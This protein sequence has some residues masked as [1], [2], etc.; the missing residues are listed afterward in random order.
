MKQ[1]KIALLIITVTSILSACSSVR[2]TPVEIIT[3]TEPRPNIVLPK[4]DEFRARNVEWIVVTPENVEQVFNDLKDKNMSV[5]LFSLSDTG[6]E[7][8]SLN[9]ADIIKLIQ[10]QQSII[11]AY[12]RYYEAKQT[13]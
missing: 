1:L 12:E 3:V 9:M 8:I 2:P 5:V 6:Y 10:Q 13:E 7:N 11:A 4:V